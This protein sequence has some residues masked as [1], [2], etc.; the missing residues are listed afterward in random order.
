[1]PVKHLVDGL[2]PVKG[3]VV[4]VLPPDALDG[5]LVRWTELLALRGTR[6]AHIVI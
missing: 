5:Q 3:K 1:M 4:R 2:D 6:L